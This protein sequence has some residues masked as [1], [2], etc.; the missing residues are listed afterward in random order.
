MQKRSLMYVL[1]H[2][3][4]LRY[5]DDS[6][7]QSIKFPPHLTTILIDP[8]RKG[9]DIKFLDQLLAFNP[10]KIIYISCNVHTQ[11]RDV[12]HLIRESNRSV[13][14]ADEGSGK[15]FWIESLRAADLFAQTHHAEGVAVLRRKV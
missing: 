3:A 11:A 2:T 1:S 7:R 12:G 14:G 13:E 10:E 15:G 8:P 9:C 5:A 4:P 6:S